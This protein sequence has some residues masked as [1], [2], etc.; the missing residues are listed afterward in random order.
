MAKARKE[1]DPTEC[2][3][4]FSGERFCSERWNSR[5]SLPPHSWERVEMIQP[6]HVVLYRDDAGDFVFYGQLERQVGRSTGSKLRKKQGHVQTGLRS[7]VTSIE[8]ISFLWAQGKGWWGKGLMSCFESQRVCLQP[9]LGQKDRRKEKHLLPSVIYLF[10]VF[11]YLA[12]YLI[13]GVFSCTF[14]YLQGYCY[15]KST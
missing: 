9:A 6:G 5:A 2:F 8:R 11:H 10:S 14:Q 15:I 4:K 1:N 7:P 12:L 13:N 3:R